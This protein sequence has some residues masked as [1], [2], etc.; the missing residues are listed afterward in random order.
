MPPDRR[1]G[2]WPAGAARTLPPEAIIMNLYELRNVELERTAR[3]YTY[4][5][6][7]ESLTIRAGEKI[8]LIGPSGCG[9]STALDL[10]AL[11]LRPSRAGTFRLETP[12]GGTED[13]AELWRKDRQ[14]RMARIRL[15]HIGYVLQT[16]GLLPFLN[17]ADNIAAPG[18]AK[19]LAAGAVKARL[20]ELADRLGIAHLLGKL[21]DR[22][23]IG[24]RQRVAIARA[25]L[26]EPELVLA[27]EPTAALDPVTA[28][29]VMRLFAE[30]ADRCALVVVSHDHRLVE[31]NG[32]RC[33]RLDVDGGDGVINTTLRGE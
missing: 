26:P 22:L 1:T 3:D 29:N 19:G 15:R 2:R 16:G 28:G 6:R 4:R 18:R 31:A 11:I 17:S 9:K 32:F 12:G 23:S 7:I 13:V 10:L 21:P 8:A 20:G 25:L 27:D 14:E 24:E 5:L 33:L 30:L